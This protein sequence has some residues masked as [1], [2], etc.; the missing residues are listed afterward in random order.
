[1]AIPCTRGFICGYLDTG[2]PDH[3]IDHGIPSRGTK[4]A[5]P[6]LSAHY[7]LDTGTKGYDV[8]ITS[9]ASSIV[10]ASATQHCPRRSCYD[11]AEGGGS[12]RWFVPTSSLHSEALLL[13]MSVRLRL[14]G[15]VTDILGM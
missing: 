13:F 11:Y 12:A 7:D 9:S 5:A 3:D 6:T 15:S 4:V 2:K 8:M 1:M 14:R 10:Q